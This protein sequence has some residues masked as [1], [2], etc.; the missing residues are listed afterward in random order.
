MR[1]KK[2][3]DFGKKNMGGWSIE[4]RRF[5]GTL[6]ILAT[7]TGLAGVMKFAKSDELED[8]LAEV[9]SGSAV[10]DTCNATID[11]AVSLK[12]RLFSPYRAELNAIQ[13]DQL[14]VAA[15]SI[16]SIQKD[17]NREEWSA[18]ANGA[19]TLRRLAVHRARV[20]FRKAE[21]E[22][23][24][25]VA[26]EA[27]M[28]RRLELTEQLNAQVAPLTAEKNTLQA[29]ISNLDSRMFAMNSRAND[30]RD[31]IAALRSDVASYESANRIA[32]GE[33]GSR[34]RARHQS[35]RESACRGTVQ[36]GARA[37]ER[38]VSY[39]AYAGNGEQLSE[40]SA[41]LP[42][43]DAQVVA[44]NE[45]K[46][47]KKNRAEALSAQIVQ[48]NEQNRLAMRQAEEVLASSIVA[49]QRGISETSSLIERADNAQAGLER[50]MNY[51]VAVLFSTLRQAH[52]WGCRSDQFMDPMSF[53]RRFGRP[54][55]DLVP[56][57]LN[58][59]E[60]GWDRQSGMLQTC[61][62]M[63][64]KPEFEDRIVREAG[65]DLTATSY[66]AC[67][68]IDLA[69]INDSFFNEGGEF[70]PNKLQ[71][72]VAP[73]EDWLFVI[74]H[75]RNDG[76]GLEYNIIDVV[77]ST[78]APECRAAYHERRLL[79]M[80]GPVATPAAP[81]SPAPAVVSE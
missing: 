79:E 7:C 12:S 29:A 21:F 30:L 13:Q 44:L 4:T 54:S 47:T 59:S 39:S 49:P 3:K 48:L 74:D 76:D 71:S 57:C 20:G 69:Q 35:S 5:I 41:A 42:L 1:H 16:H 26:E 60:S 61:R 55:G 37:Q 24:I 33:Q 23:M 14:R 32:E 40:F 72:L 67:V 70:L 6:A 78:L 75:D 17:I 18:L 77:A 68:S 80:V 10:S 66:R 36:R 63:D 64:R 51:R 62:I 31:K 8:L 45:E 56:E 38:C 34:A 9:G 25:Q 73:S 28:S 50:Q 58:L 52:E 19:T 53:G 65:F 43:V 2:V 27:A 46:T 22:R 15:D 81:A 11:L